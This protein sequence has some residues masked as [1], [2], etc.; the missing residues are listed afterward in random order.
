MSAVASTMGLQATAQGMCGEWSHIPFSGD[1]NLFSTRPTS[2]T[3]VIPRAEVRERQ[4]ILVHI[5][6][7][8]QLATA[9][10]E[11][12][13]DGESIQNPGGDHAASDRT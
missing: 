5:V 7:D 12:S 13:I 2:Y 9:Q 11:A 4:S 8:V 1:P 6:R 3:S 10:V